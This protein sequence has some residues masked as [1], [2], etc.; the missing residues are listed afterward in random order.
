MTLLHTTTAS[1]HISPVS[2]GPTMFIS[3]LRCVEGACLERSWLCRTSVCEA[4]MQP[5]GSRDYPAASLE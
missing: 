1:G 2:D 4:V 5:F 3:N